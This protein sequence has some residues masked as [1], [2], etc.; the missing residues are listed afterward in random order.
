[1]ASAAQLQATMSASPVYDQREI[2]DTL[3]LAR[4][5]NHYVRG[6]I[7]I[8]PNYLSQC[9]DEWNREKSLFN[10]EA[11]GVTP[12]EFITSNL[13]K[14]AFIKEAM[15]EDRAMTIRDLA[16]N[17]IEYG[18]GNCVVMSALGFQYAQNK[19]HLIEMFSIES[20]TGNHTFLVLDRDPASRPDDY[21]N[22]GKR[23]IICDPWIDQPVPD[24][25]NKGDAY[26][27]S[28][29]RNRLKVFEEQTY[30]EKTDTF[31]TRLRPFNPASQ[32]LDLYSIK[33]KPDRL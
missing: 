16:K 6:I 4:E 19:G 29:I 12:E 31:Y 10:W 21:L 33:G 27:A 3:Q 23:A 11:E 20:D 7:R 8:I 5:I 17:A 15:K 32:R 22:W 25:L 1:M 2:S 24:Y 18:I 30:N 28:E 14:F 9:P 26:P 13:W